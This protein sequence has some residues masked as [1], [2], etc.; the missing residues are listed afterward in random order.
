MLFPPQAS[1]SN[2]YFVFTVGFYSGDLMEHHE[3]TVAFPV[4]DFKGEDPRESED[5][6]RVAVE[7]LH[8]A[9]NGEN[10]DLI[11]VNYLGR[12]HN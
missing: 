11:T 2:H 1:P 9:R 6:I 4:E 7:G 12:G 3:E 5:L 10:D 8:R